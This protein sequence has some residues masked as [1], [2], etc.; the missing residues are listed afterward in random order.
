MHFM[1]YIFIARK[2]SYLRELIKNISNNLFSHQ[3]L[4]YSVEI[5]YL[6]LYINYNV[7]FHSF[8]VPR[9]WLNFQYQ[10]SL[11]LYPFHMNCCE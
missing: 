3:K 7:Y 1:V 8:A 2:Y 11:K 9:E 5:I 6:K 4:R 10:Y